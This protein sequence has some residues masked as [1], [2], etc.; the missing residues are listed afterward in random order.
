VAGKR[1]EFD[2]Q[3]MAELLEKEQLDITQPVFA[4]KTSGAFA[5]KYYY[6]K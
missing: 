1:K 3:E 2:D 4:A 5:P 6:S